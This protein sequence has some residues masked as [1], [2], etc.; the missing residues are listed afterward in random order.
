M[1]T[2]FIYALC[3]PDTLEVRY[4]GKTDNVYNRFYQHLADKKHTHK[5]CW[6]QAVLKKGKIPIYQIVE[7]CDESIWQQREI[8]WINF[9]RNIGYDL[10]N[11]TAGGEGVVGYSFSE[12]VRK[13]LSFV[14]IGKKMN[15]ATIEKIRIANLGKKRSVVSK[16]KMRL[17]KLEKKQSPESI[18]KRRFAMMGHSV[19]VE[20][21]EKI[22]ASKIGNNNPA[23][24]PDVRAKISRTL[25]GNIPWNKGKS[26]SDSHRAKLTLSHLGKKASDETKDKMRKSR[27]HESRGCNTL[28]DDFGR[29][30]KKEK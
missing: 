20:A 4:I 16:Y 22:R 30:C 21:R 24:N 29:F 25:H 13:K 9:Y 2:T 5:T 26:L 3:D 10:V 27:G 15:P 17:A 19:S 8:D 6:I 12:E 28:H 14:R 7:E 11:L 23:K 18:K 1:A